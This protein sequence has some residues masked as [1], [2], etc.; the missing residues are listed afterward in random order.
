MPTYVSDASMA[1]S[2]LQAINGHGRVIQRP[3]TVFVEIQW[4]LELRPAW[5][6]NNLGYD[7]NFSFELTT[8]VLSYDLN[9]GQG[10]NVYAL[11]RF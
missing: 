7:Q 4:T 6:T 3:L 2:Q 5:H 1:W 9:S 10:Q 8:K 11:V